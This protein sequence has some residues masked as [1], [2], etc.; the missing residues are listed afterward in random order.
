MFIGSN[1]QN[2]LLKNN[3]VGITISRCSLFKFSLFKLFII[4][5][6]DDYHILQFCISLSLIN[7]FQIEKH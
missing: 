5:I 3:L 4:L 2:M 1:S 6:K 7:N